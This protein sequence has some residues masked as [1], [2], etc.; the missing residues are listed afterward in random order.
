MIGSVP[1][2]SSELIKRSEMTIRIAERKAL[3]S[4]FLPSIRTEWRP[5]SNMP[6]GYPKASESAAGLVQWTQKDLGIVAS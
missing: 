5:G 2:R 3:F 1:G 6:Y 4:V